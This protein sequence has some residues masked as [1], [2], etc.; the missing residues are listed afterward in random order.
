[1]VTKHGG[2]RHCAGK[3][4]AVMNIKIR[5]DSYGLIERGIFGDDGGSI[6]SSGIWSAGRF[7]NA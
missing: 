1:M 5:G 6:G 7:Q 3:P 4:V 2:W